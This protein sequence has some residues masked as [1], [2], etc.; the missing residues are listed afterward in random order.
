MKPLARPGVRIAVLAIA[1]VFAAAACGTGKSPGAPSTANAGAFGKVPPAASG[2]QHAGTVT[3]AEAP[4][5]APTWILPVTSSAAFNVNDTTQFSYEMWRPLYWF[6]N[7]VEPTETPSMSL[8]EPPK[9]SNGDKTVS[10]TLKGSYKWSDGQP[11]TAK[12]VLFFFDEIKA[13]IKEDPSNWGPYTPGLGMP[14]DV[15]SVSTP[16]ASTI[17][18][19]LKQAVNPGWFFD[20]QL[21]SLNPMPS[22]AWAKASASGPLLDFTVPANAKSIFD[23][24]NNASKSEATYT[25]NPLWQVVDG[26]YKLTQFNSSSGAF[27][28][29]PNPSYGGPHAKQIS[30]LQA[31]P[32]TSDT[33]EFNAVRAGSIDVGYLPLTD[34]KQVP[35]V[36]QS[37]YNVFGYPGFSFAYVAYNFLDKTGDFDKIISQLYFRQVIAHLENEQGYIKAFFGGAGGPAY[38]PIP[39]IPR[40][41]YVPSNAVTDPYPF[42]VSAAVALLKNHGWAVHPGGTDTCAKPGSG[43]GEC[44]AGIPAGTRLSFNLIYTTAPAVVGEMVTDLASQAAKAGITINL[45]SSNFNYIVTYYDNP[46]PSGKPYINKWAM[47]DFGGFTDSTYP[48]TL[49]IFNGPGS[50]NEGTYSDPTADK[51][52]N[53]SVN[54]SDPTA[55]KNEASYLTKSQPGL[56]QPN[57]DYVVVWKKTISGNPASFANQTQA[58]LTPEY[59]YFTK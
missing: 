57:G 37:G 12:D 17:V 4:G 20:D 21:S 39:S 53:A 25:T 46:V 7:G 13:G 50:L 18:F 56:F 16:T 54:S 51:L 30:T 44:G 28:M 34:I 40:S 36:Q 11:V 58:Y 55:V 14:D 19:N 10:V 29:S 22:H 33:A 23:F 38:G 5:T 1:T 27:T 42:S 32:F 2:P 45:R 35:A 8:A 9:W 48:T 26:P 49:S 3:W 6:S 43:A 41:P 24:L 31:V 47:E 15:A 52:I 59:W